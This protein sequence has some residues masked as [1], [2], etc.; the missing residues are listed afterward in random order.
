MPKRKSRDAEDEP[1]EAQD[2]T[3]V[4]YNCRSSEKRS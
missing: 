2:D 3:G 1:S 4:R